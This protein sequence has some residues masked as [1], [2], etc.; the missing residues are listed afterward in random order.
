M[1]QPALNE[2]L[3]FTAVALSSVFFAVDPLAAIPAFLVMG[4]D[5]PVRKQRQAARSAALT[6]FVILSLF[7]MAGTLIFKTFGITLPAFRIAGGILLFQLGME[8]LQAKRSG[9]QEVA[10]EREEGMEKDDYGVIPMGMPML[11][12]PAAISA[13]MVLVAQSRVWWQVAIVYSVIAFTA[14]ATFSLLAA[15][16]RVQQY[17]GETG[18]RILVRMMGLVLAAMAVQFIINGVTDVVSSLRG[19]GL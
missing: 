17:L 3:Q 7:A 18:L 19:R 4:S 15:G 6:L 10:E 5:R 16:N 9:T 13:V 14:A 1:A 2:V 11:A 12:G 8:M